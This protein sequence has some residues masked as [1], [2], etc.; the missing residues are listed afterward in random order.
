MCGN[1]FQDLKPQIIKLDKTRE[2]YIQKV[3]T[4]LFLVLVHVFNIIVFIL[5]LVPNY[6]IIFLH[7]LSKAAVLVKISNLLVC[8]VFICL[9][10]Y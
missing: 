2:E 4:A 7:H 3:T 5:F 9:V 10:L 6:V 1:K 8:V